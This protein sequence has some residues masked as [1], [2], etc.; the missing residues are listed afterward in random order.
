[1]LLTPLL[2]STISLPDDVLFI[3]TENDSPET[4]LLALRNGA[5][6]N[7]SSD[8]PFTRRYNEYIT[9]LE[10][11]VH[12]ERIGIISLLL[13]A[14]A[15]VTPAAMHYAAAHS[16]S[17]MAELFLQNGAKP[18]STYHR[19]TPLYSAAKWG[20]PESVRMLLQAGADVS[21]R[22]GMLIPLLGALEGGR[23]DAAQILLE[24]GANAN[25]RDEW[26]RR[27]IALL[28]WLRGR[29]REEIM[30]LMVKC[31]AE[32]ALE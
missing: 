14:G 22:P 31:G 7:V 9:P 25:L 19:M 32:V 20:H 23:A 6:V 13:A 29:E 15:K 2:H 3:A 11:A 26:G 21:C 24:A 16:Q 12:D 5:N 8:G 27:V 10:A 1:M 28:Y 4:A 30:E 17:R 18:M